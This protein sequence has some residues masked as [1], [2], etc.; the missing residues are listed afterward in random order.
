MHALTKET[1]DT[2]LEAMETY[3]RVAQEL[4]DKLI[5]ET[6]Q[7]EK[8]EIIDGA[9]HLLSNEEVLNGEEYLSGNWHFDVHG[10]HCMFEN[11]E[12]GQTLEVSL[13]SKNDVG[14]M[15]P[16]FFYNF[17]K[18]TANYEHLI[19][20]FEN[21]FGDMLN[22]FERLAAQNVLIHVHGVEYRKLL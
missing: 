18:S 14:N 8:S 4:I 1:T 16:Y 12:T 7:A 9:Y 6:S 3:K 17:L 21:P 20:Y 22:L 15:D 2:L 5:S 19:A 10:E 13:G 11:A